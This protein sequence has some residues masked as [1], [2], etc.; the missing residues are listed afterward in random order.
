MADHRFLT[1]SSPGAQSPRRYCGWMRG[2]ALACLAVTAAALSVWAAASGA[3][4][5]DTADGC[6]VVQDGI[7]ALGL[8]LQGIAFGKFDQGQIVVDDSGG[9][10]PLPL[11]VFNRGAVKSIVRLGPRRWRYTGA[12]LRF[13]ASG[14]FK[15]TVNASGLDLSASGTGTATL[16]TQFDF[17]GT[18]SVD[19]TSF[20]DD[21]FQ[22]LPH[23]PKTYTVGSQ[24]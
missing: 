2:R 23:T 10:G 22:P 11:T 14:A 17:A 1:G 9:S 4:T 16:S 7:G 20:C 8:D 5:R 6:L 24:P 18:F 15:V 21:G 19:Q 12:G 13:K 3:T